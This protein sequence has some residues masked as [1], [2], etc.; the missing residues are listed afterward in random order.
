MQAN[1]WVHEM[2]GKKEIRILRPNMPLTEI[3]LQLENSIAF[4]NSILLENIGNEID[5]VFDAILQNKKIKQGG[6]WKLKMGE[7][8][9][10]YSPNFKL[11][12]TTKL[13]NP[14]YPPEICVK[15][16]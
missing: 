2:V 13:P 6:A 16:I 9:I 8:I 3:L 5:S 7:K 11:Y 14:H 4:G 10:D 15:V 1:I 12:M